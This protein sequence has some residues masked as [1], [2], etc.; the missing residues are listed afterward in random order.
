M[1]GVLAVLA[2]V[3]VWYVRLMYVSELAADVAVLDAAVMQRALLDTRFYRDGVQLVSQTHHQ[4]V[5][6]V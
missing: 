5:P 1:C 6:S 4:P 3:V 2:L